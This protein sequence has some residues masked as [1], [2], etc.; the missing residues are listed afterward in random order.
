M[1]TQER[2]IKLQN[3]P[4]YL[5]NQVLNNN[6]KAVAQKAIAIGLFNYEASPE[7]IANAIGELIRQRAYA[8]VIQ[9]LDV[10]FIPNTGNETDQN[11]DVFAAIKKVSASGAKTADGADDGSTTNWLAI[12][13]GA[14]TGALQ[15]WSGQVNG[16]QLAA[17][18]QPGTAAATAAS[19]AAQAQ[20]S[21]SNLLYI[22]LGIFGFVV[23]GVIVYVVVKASN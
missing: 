18:G 3:D 8:A 17:A 21:S 11:A 23:L 22:G 1:T 15:S 7:E 13:L 20:K 16:Q 5:V 4:A 19:Q 12:G 6:P 10:P 14:V 9:L 2:L